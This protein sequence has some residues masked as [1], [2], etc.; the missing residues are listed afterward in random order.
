MKNIQMH[1]YI[2]VVEFRS[3]LDSCHSQN[4]VVQLGTTEL[5]FCPIWLQRYHPSH[6]SHLVVDRAVELFS[7][8]DVCK[9][10]VYYSVVCH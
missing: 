7:V 9:I 4:L 5:N 2:T 6:L 8:V 3:D 1:V 10:L